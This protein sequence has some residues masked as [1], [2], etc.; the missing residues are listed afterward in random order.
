[1]R[2]VIRLEPAM[3]T[4]DFTWRETT[5]VLKNEQELLGAAAG[6]L[7]VSIADGLATVQFNHPPTRN[8]IS[9]EMWNAIGRIF[10]ALAEDE[11]VDLVIVRG[12]PGG[13]F[14]SGADITEFATLRSDVANAR[15]YS[16]AVEQGGRAIMQFPRPTIAMVEGFAI[17]GGSEVALACDIRLSDTNARFGITPAKL[18]LVYGLQSTRRLVETVGPAWARWILYTGLQIDA[19]T[20]LRIGL[21]HQIYPVGELERETHDLARHVARLARVSIEGAKTMIQMAAVQPGPDHADRLAETMI[22][23][24][25][26]ST[27]YAEGVRAFLE[28]RPP[29]FR[30]ARGTA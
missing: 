30:G 2:T 3:P 7:G 13:P 18:G 1:M 19:A 14:S 11:S 6:R 21:V 8:A 17:G 27:E 28:K 9:F 15:R 23:E 10:T 4:H 24:S 12:T 5:G 16:A 20:A 29:D 22:D 25:T 26:K